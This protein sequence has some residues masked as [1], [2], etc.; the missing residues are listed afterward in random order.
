MPGFD[1]KVTT[2]AS[3]VY[4]IERSVKL[5]TD[6]CNVAKRNMGPG[7]IVMI[8]SWNNFQ[9]G[10][11]MEPATEYG[12]KYLQVTMSMFKLN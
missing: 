3:K 5:Y 2:P 10:T 4:T 1:D 6:M 12:S 9:Q 11:T 7:R 8:N